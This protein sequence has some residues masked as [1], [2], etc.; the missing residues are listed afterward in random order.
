MNLG[1]QD[2]SFARL[3]ALL[4]RWFGDQTPVLDALLRGLAHLVSV[5]YDLIRYA[6]QQTRIKTATADWLDLM[7][8]DFFGEA[9]RRQVGQTDTAYRQR[10]IANLFRER[11]TRAGLVKLVTELTGRAPTVFEPHRLADS[12]AYGYSHYGQARYGARGYPF[13]AWVSVWRAHDARLPPK[14]GFYEHSQY[15]Q[16]SYASRQQLQGALSDA[17]LLLAI[18]RVKPIGTVIWVKLI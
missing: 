4:P 10:L 9:L 2:D 11:A 16:V 13:Q 1:D 3:K 6:K 17:E 8:Q 5:G 15:E 18:H 12:A 14:A 7:A